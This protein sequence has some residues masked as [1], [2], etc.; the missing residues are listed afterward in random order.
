ML[1]KYDMR[2]TETGTKCGYQCDKE[3]IKQIIKHWSSVDMW[4]RVYLP[5][6][7]VWFYADYVGGW[8]RIKAPNK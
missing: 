8:K 5:N 1:V 6:G 2:T 3:E 7:A 4:L